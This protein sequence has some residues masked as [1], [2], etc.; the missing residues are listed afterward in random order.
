MRFSGKSNVNVHFSFEY[1]NARP[2][3]LQ[4]P[5]VHVGPSHHVS[6]LLSPLI[7][8]AHSCMVFVYCGYSA[9]SASAEYWIYFW[10]DL[11]VFTRSAVT[12]PKMNRFI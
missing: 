5:M 10:G 9:R 11:A 3:V 7:V 6:F 12:P 2:S 4:K 1:R 8:L